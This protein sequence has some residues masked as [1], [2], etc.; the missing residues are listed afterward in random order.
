MVSPASTGTTIKIGEQILVV[1]LHLSP[2]KCVISLRSMRLLSEINKILITYL[3]PRHS[4]ARFKLVTP[5]SI[6]S[7]PNGGKL[8]NVVHF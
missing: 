8:V 1:R 4:S 2:T 5:T 3:V 6:I 7:T